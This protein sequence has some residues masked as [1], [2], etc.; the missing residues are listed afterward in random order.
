MKYKTDKIMKVH[1]D[2]YSIY[3]EDIKWKACYLC[4]GT[5]FKL[6]A[7]IGRYT[8]FSCTACGLGVTGPFPSPEVFSGYEVHDTTIAWQQDLSRKKSCW[9]STGAGA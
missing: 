6:W 3:R 4:E 8:V 1:S 7:Q 9:R 2:N 5:E